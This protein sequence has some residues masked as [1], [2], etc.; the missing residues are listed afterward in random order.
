MSPNLLTVQPDTPLE[1]VADIFHEH[2]VKSLP[3]IGPGGTL[4][5]RVLRA[6]LFDW[7]WKG[8]RSQQQRQSLW[9]RMR[10]PRAPAEPLA[11][12]LMRAPELCVQESTPMGDLLHALSSDSLQ[13][14]AV[15]RGKVLVGV[16]TRSDVI[17]TL[18][19]L[20]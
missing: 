3:V 9:R 4:I 5:G 7:L 12:S 17:R 19:A 8:H 6:D 11:V 2:L 16:I 14:I 10:P 20:K 1:Q 15:L 18:L 13:F